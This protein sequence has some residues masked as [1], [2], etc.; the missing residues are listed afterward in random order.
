MFGEVRRKGDLKI[1]APLEQDD[2]TVLMRA[3]F[4]LLMTVCVVCR[5][6]L[7][8]KM[9]FRKLKR[10]KSAVHRLL[11][12]RWPLGSALKQLSEPT[13]A[14]RKRLKAQPR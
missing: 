9:A 6:A 12:C 14:R 11:A 1:V 8:K 13:E 2:Y 4:I 7:Y 10:C 5:K 3:Y